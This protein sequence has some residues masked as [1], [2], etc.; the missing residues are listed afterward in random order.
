M[1][2]PDRVYTPEELA[3]FARYRDQR[4]L[5]R[6]VTCAGGD[7]CWVTH[8]PPA[9]GGTGNLCLGCKRMPSLLPHG[10]SRAS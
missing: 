5:C 8:G 7:D 4:A 10:F 9:F 3:L 1:T 2:P 6:P